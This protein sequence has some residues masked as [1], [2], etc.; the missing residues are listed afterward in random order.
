M[1][2]NS[3]QYSDSLINDI[4]V[5]ECQRQN[6]HIELI[7]SENIVSKA[8]LEAAGSV[9][10]NKYAEGYPYK[11][12]YAGCEF[13]DE[14]EIIAQER[15]KQLFNCEYANVQPH[16]GSQANQAVYLAFLKPG[17]TVLGMSLDAGGHLTH[18]A[19][20]NLSGLWFN[21]ITYGV[22]KE[23]YLIDYDQV[24]YLAKKHKPKLIVAGFSAYPRNI[25]WKIFRQIADS[26]GAKL[27]ADIAHI[28]GLVA[29]GFCESPINYADI[30]TSTTHKT[31]RGPRGGVI[32]SRDMTFAKQLN[33]ALFPGI[34]GGP[35][36]HIIAAKAVAFGE[37]LQSSFKEYIVNVVKNASAMASRFIN[38]SI[39]I[40]TKGTDNHIILID[41]RS[42]R[43]TGKEIEQKLNSFG[44][45]C[46]K[47]AIAYDSL[48]PTITSGIRLGTPACTTR[49]FGVREFEILADIISEVILGNYNNIEQRVSELCSKFP[50]SW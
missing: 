4:I 22:R 9:L 42:R 26:V 44:I 40:V 2:N 28:A 31:L 46:N 5:K 16:S 21:A 27:M 11:R 36:M 35:L 48:P 38:N 24:E 10:T 18:G 34:Q 8:V 43:L 30:V 33:S 19:S 1:K 23:D 13:V 20:K 6:N 41:L 7:A 12:Y 39:D 14:I 32:M 25:D 47:N 17:D 37:C 45:I 29:T 3:I 15:L 49:G 50:I